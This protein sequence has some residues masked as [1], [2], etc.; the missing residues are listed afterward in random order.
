MGIHNP[1]FTRKH[2]CACQVANIK[3]IPPIFVAISWSR[4]GHKLLSAATDCTVSIWDVFSGD[5]DHTYRFPSPVL[6]VQFHP[7][8]E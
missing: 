6:K 2:V 5:C 8:D 1:T 7:R 3:L 4:S